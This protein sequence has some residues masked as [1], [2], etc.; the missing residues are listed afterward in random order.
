M[1]FGRRT[2][3]FLLL[4]WDN[5]Y[6]MMCINL[7]KWLILIGGTAKGTGGGDSKSGLLQPLEI[8]GRPFK[9]QEI[10]QH[11]ELCSFSFMAVE[12]I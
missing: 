1:D 2:F 8:L 11:Q 3:S 9:I 4:I 12:P 7:V 10:I 5:H 6:L